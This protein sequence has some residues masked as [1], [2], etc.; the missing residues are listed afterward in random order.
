MF[1]KIK[2]GQYN[3]TYVYQLYYSSTDHYHFIPGSNFNTTIKSPYRGV[4]ILIFIFL[5]LSLSYLFAIQLLARNCLHYFGQ[6]LLSCFLFL[7]CWP[8]LTLEP[9]LWLMSSGPAF[10]IS[11]RQVLS[12]VFSI[13]RCIFFEIEK[14]NYLKIPF[15]ELLL[16]G[17]GFHEHGCNSTAFIAATIN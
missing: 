5:S 1:A 6:F 4:V 12:L 16:M 2:S 8:L 9:A 10:I 13:D 11:N 7:S 14:S 3:E 17:F 15:K